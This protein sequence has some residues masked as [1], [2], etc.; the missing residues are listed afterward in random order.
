MSR[1]GFLLASIA[2]G[3]LL[4]SNAGANPAGIHPDL[5]SILAGKGDRD[6]VPVIVILAQAVDLESLGSVT[7]KARRSAMIRAMKRFAA[8]SQVPLKAFLDKEGVA[9]V[10]S[11]WLINGL[12]V[13]ARP[14]VIR[15]LAKFPGVSKVLPDRIIPL[16]DTAPVVGPMAQEW[17]LG[18][19]EVP[20]VWR[21]GFR[22]QGVVVAN[23]DTGADV[24]H[25]DLESRWRGGANSW[26][27]PFQRT[28]V[29]YDVRGHGTQTMGI[30]VGG[31][32][33][34]TAIGVAPKARWIAA[35]IFNDSGS[36][37]SSVIH[38]A[39]Q[40]LLD[41]D[42]DPDTDDAP[43]VVNCSW[44]VVN[45]PGQCIEDFYGDIRTLRR[46]GIAV[47]FSAGNSGEMGSDSSISPANNP[48][49]FSVGAVD[50]GNNIAYF[51]SLGPSACTG[52]FF[53]TVV[54]PG[55]GVKSADPVSAGV[56]GAYAVVDGTSFSAPHVSGTMA[57]LLSAFPGLSV[58]MLEAALKA[59]ALDL[60]DGGADNTYGR[61]LISALE[62]LNYLQS[63]VTKATLNSVNAQDGWIRESSRIPGTG[64]SARSAGNVLVGD[65]AGNRQLVGIFSF[66]TS[67]LPANAVITSARLFLTRKA[68]RG[69]NPF[70]LL[71]KCFVDL[72]DGTFNATALE[73]RDF[74]AAT[75]FDRAARM[76][77]P[78]QNGDV[79]VGELGETALRAIPKGSVAQVRVRFSK[80]TNKNSI[81]DQVV[82]WGDDGVGTQKP[83]LEITYLIP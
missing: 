47:V 49:V 3:L 2:L 48:G 37:T 57:L 30:M 31:K 81:A 9:Q 51:S 18:A 69:T 68:V 46:A 45:A 54:A 70:T 43:D 72:A 10:Q 58:P 21:L 67:S 78:A 50:S 25:P 23:M 11:L 63:R 4:A 52:K 75:P 8:F 41:P 15:K 71:D 44:G 12:A 13:K 79:S 20:Q 76:S 35:K 42:G 17:N 64:A 38:Q 29:P 83:R 16:F 40:W 55:A 19:V 36:S 34:G 60:G 62:A 61:G 66:N 22:G 32:A 6:E 39:F 56:Q 33:G 1:W 80:A 59:S 53:P 82:F 77:N 5:E 24:N 27:D 74:Q 7:G 28:S 65:D 73:T 14:G 26:W